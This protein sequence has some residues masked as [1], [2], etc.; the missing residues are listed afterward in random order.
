M[1][2]DEDMLMWLLLE[3][4][5]DVREALELVL[6]NGGNQLGVSG[7]KHG[8]FSSELWVEVGGLALALDCR[9]EWGRHLEVG[10]LDPVNVAEEGVVL[11]VPLSGR[12]AAKTLLGVASQELQ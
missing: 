5:V 2:I 9:L 11:D 7:R 6:V 1:A 4:G 3:A 8:L 10:K 12:A